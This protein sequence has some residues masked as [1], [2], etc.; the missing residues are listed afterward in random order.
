M[1]WGSSVKSREC[2]FSP[3]LSKTLR[4]LYVLILRSSWRTGDPHPGVVVNVALALQ[5]AKQFE[6]RAQFARVGPEAYGE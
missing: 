1:L 3:V 4:P 6:R 2:A 5:L